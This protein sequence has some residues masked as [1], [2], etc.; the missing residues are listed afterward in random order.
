MDQI[1]HFIVLML[2]NRSFDHIFGYLDHPDPDFDGVGRLPNPPTTMDARYAIYPGPDH[3]HKGVMHQVLGRVDY[4]GHP[5]DNY[6][7]TM[8]GFAANYELHAKDRGQK[9][10]RCF[11]PRM[12]PVM[13]KL[14][15]EYAV[16]DRWFCSLPGETFPNRDFAHAGTSFGH[17]NI[18]SLFAG[19]P[20]PKLKNPPTIFSMLDAAQVSWRVYHQGLAH[21]LIYAQLFLKDDRRGSHVQLLEDIANSK[22]PAYSFV[23]PDYGILGAGNSMHPSQ[24]CSRE[25]FVNGEAFIADIYRALRHNKKLFEKTA[26]IITFDE[27]GGFYDHVP[28]RYLGM[29]DADPKH[30][31]KDGAYEFWFKMSGPRVPAIVISPWIDAGTVDHTVR[32]HSSIPETIRKRFLKN[33]GYPLNDRGEGTD[34][35]NLFT[36][37]TPRTDLPDVEPLTHAEAKALEEE[38]AAAPDDSDLDPAID[39]A[40]QTALHDVG[41]LLKSLGKK[42]LGL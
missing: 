8:S 25:E 21:S 14:A 30:I 34:L 42:I 10:M 23:E 18:Y 12:V 2:E 26:L 22:L 24:A 9:V 32:D 40:L 17:A 35:G 13:S 28:A 38:L 37:A 16:C 19:I 1:E 6:N 31:Y 39:I 20:A 36:R 3:S 15:L 5:H 29:P 4:E 7:P 11:N 41:S 33:V 27:H